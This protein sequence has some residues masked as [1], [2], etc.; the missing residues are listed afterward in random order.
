MDPIRHVVVLMLENRS[1]D[2]ALGGLQSAIP[3]LKGVAN[4]GS[5]PCP[6]GKVT[7]A[8]VADPQFKLDPP[9]EHADVLAQIGKPRAGAMQGFVTEFAKRHAKSDSKDWQQVMAYFRDGD[10]PVLHRLA[11]EFMV[12]NNW[13]S[14][15][16]GPTWPN[17]FFVHSG[18][19]LGH[20]LTP[21][22][23]STIGNVRLY[24]QD[25]IYDRLTAEGIKWRIYHDGLPQ[26]LALWSQWK[27]VL[28]NYAGMGRFRDHAMGSE[29]KFP[30]YSFI[31]PR[32][33]GSWQNDQHPP[34]DALRGDALVASVYN[35]IRA[36]DKL[37][38]ASLL[39][40]L[41]DEHGGF[42]DQAYPP[43]APPP[44]WHTKRYAFDQYGVR[45]PAVLISPWLARG[46]DDTVYDHTSVLKYAIGKWKLR[47]LGERVDKAN[48]IAANLLGKPR[49][50]TP[51]R[52]TGA[53]PLPT[54]TR[55]VRGQPAPLNDH[56]RAL[57][58]FMR[59]IHND[60]T[61]ARRPLA[62]LREAPLTQKEGED[63][64]VAIARY[65]RNNKTRALELERERVR[66]ARRAAGR[67]VAIAFFKR[68][69]RQAM[70]HAARSLLKKAMKR[71]RS[72][73]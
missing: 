9:H 18:T 52:V 30:A 15:M 20:F 44:D 21:N 16:P 14:S 53:K 6:S 62:A 13:Y 65:L 39:V 42:Y 54:A 36:N 63:Q 35:A 2:H 3:D 45:V 43:K 66:L 26:S 59:G 55:K 1:F 61:Q 12:C 73:R 19:S 72:A 58:A 24:Y 28:G 49:K 37:W 27:Y 69:N 11:K 10:L 60:V 7:Q 34:S 51:R 29:R 50:D 25:T 32:Y 22:D 23:L 40:I 5:N 31:E 47:G 17:R 70:T 68:V 67:Q 4:P 41:H 46:V 48:P 8:A 56:Q 33:F 57:L 38:N 71:P 64:F